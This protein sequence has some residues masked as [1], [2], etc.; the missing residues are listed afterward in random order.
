MIH[1]HRTEL[2][3]RLLDHVDTVY[4]LTPLLQFLNLL[5]LGVLLQSLLDITWCMGVAFVAEVV[6]SDVGVVWRVTKR[7]FDR[8]RKSVVSGK[9]FTFTLYAVR[10]QQTI[11]NVLR[12]QG[13]LGRV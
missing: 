8:W 11:Y 12:I 10:L 6:Y 2:L 9:E 1:D 5:V 7:S 4:V 13:H 3:Q